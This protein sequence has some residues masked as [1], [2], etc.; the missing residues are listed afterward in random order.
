MFFDRY[1]SFPHDLKTYLKRSPARWAGRSMPSGVSRPPAP[2]GRRYYGRCSVEP[3][4][5]AEGAA[6]ELRSRRSGAGPWVGSIG[7]PS[8]LSV[9]ER[10]TCRGRADRLG[11]PDPLEC[12]L[13]SP[14]RMVQRSD[15]GAGRSFGVSVG[16][17]GVWGLTALWVRRIVGL[18]F[19]VGIQSGGLRLAVGVPGGRPRAGKPVLEMRAGRVPALVTPWSGGLAG[20][21]PAPPPDHPGAV[22]GRWA[23]ARGSDPPGARP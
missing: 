16:R 9:G 18:D 19:V 10:W 13:A 3:G 20:I 23:P 21:R 5:G 4:R 7:D 15:R 2:V 12:P 22:P 11:T 14:P 6:S 17:C 8:S 1:F